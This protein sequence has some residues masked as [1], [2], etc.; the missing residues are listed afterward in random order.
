MAAVTT[1][2]KRDSSKIDFADVETG[3]KIVVGLRDRSA[4]CANAT[5]PGQQRTTGICTAYRA[6]QLFE[7]LARIPEFCTFA[8]HLRVLP[9]DESHLRVRQP[10]EIR[11]T[12]LKFPEADW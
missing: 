4:G 3:A 10:D 1:S 8:S 11:E 5:A 7:R 12:E 6:Y 9:Q 2:T